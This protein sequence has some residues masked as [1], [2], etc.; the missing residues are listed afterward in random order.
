MHPNKDV[1]EE[2]SSAKSILWEYLH[3]ATERSAL[4]IGIISLISGMRQLGYI[5]GGE[6]VKG[7]NLALILWFLFGSMA[8][9]YLRYRES[10]RGKKVRIPPKSDWVMGNH[11]DDDSIDV[12]HPSVPSCD[13]NLHPYEGIELQFQPLY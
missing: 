6:N 7:I 12:F 1:V 11:E 13:R 8:V 5:Y 4:M 9:G 3:V 2:Q 10:K